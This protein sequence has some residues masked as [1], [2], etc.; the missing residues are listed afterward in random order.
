[1][2]NECVKVQVVRLQVSTPYLLVDPCDWQ[3]NRE[4]V[5]GCSSYRFP[6]VALLQRCKLWK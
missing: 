1:M 3:A 6:S 4:A 2:S 5:S